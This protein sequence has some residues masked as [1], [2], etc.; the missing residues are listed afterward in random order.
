MSLVRSGAYTVVASIAQAALSIVAVAIVA[1]ALGPTGKGV[2]DLYWTTANMAVMLFSLALPAGVTYTV[3]RGRLDLSRLMTQLMILSVAIGAFTFCAV[4]LLATISRFR[5]FLPSD[6]FVLQT[7]AITASALAALTLFRAVIVG[8][9]LFRRASMIDVFR[10]LSGVLSIAVAVTIGA[11]SGSWR[12]HAVVLANCFAVFMSSL[13]Y[14]G[15]IVGT[16]RPFSRRGLRS[17]PELVGALTYAAPAYLANL[18]QYLNYRIDVFF[19]SGMSGAAA[20]GNYQLAVMI[21]ESLRLLPTAAQAII[22]PTIASRQEASIANANL[23]IRTARAVF[24]VT[25]GGSLLVGG[26][27]YLAIPSLFGRG[28]AP[29][30]G[31]LVALLPGLAMFAVTTVLA[32]YISGIGMPHLNLHASMTGLI[33]TITLDFLLIPRFGIMGAAT[34]SSISYSITTA[35]MLWLFARLTGVRGRDVLIPRRS[36]LALYRRIVGEFIP[37]FTSTGSVSD[38]SALS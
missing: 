28:F 5:S 37:R 29:S 3:A 7:T 30:V 13:A 24:V 9:R 18:V 36:D 31:P 19:V 26:I 17:A 12:L 6:A 11:R 33:A 16:R 34:A 2:Y 21:A 23:T 20:L 25:V 1:R 15:G 35:Y 38:E 14:L 8:Q 10:A 32:G 4:R 22:W 27:G